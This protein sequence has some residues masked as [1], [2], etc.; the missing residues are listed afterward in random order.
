[1]DDS[2][3]IETADSSKSHAAARFGTT[4]SHSIQLRVQNCF[5]LE[6][7]AT[8][9]VNVKWFRKDSFCIDPRDNR[10][11]NIVLANSI[12]W[13]AENLKYG[14]ILKGN[15]VP[16]NNG[17]IERYV[18]PP[19]TIDQDGYYIPEEVHLYSL[20]PDS[21][22]CPPGWS[23]PD[24]ATYKSLENSYLWFNNSHE[25][26]ISGGITGINLDNVGYFISDSNKYYSSSKSYW[27][28][29]DIVLTDPYDL[30]YSILCLGKVMHFFRRPYYQ[31]GIEYFP[32]RELFQ[33]RKFALPVR[34]IKKEE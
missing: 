14:Y 31:E 25:F 13:F 29:K 7:T 12:W 5:G 24:Y 9:H 28:G 23:L 1:V 4:G 6:D 8:C 10:K 20:H 16:T 34:C 15:E 21:S 18:R 32:E 2:I 27:W 11:Y 22:I 30:T 26:F 19:W 33:Q 17:I 3:R